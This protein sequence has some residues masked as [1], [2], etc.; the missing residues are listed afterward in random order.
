M[1][2]TA[3]TTG[4][5]VAD[6]VV[7]GGGRVR[8]VPAGDQ[9]II[10][11]PY[12][13]RDGTF[14]GL[15]LAQTADE[16]VARFGSKVYELMLYD[17][18]VACAF[19]LW[20]AGIVG[21]GL[22]VAP[23]VKTDPGEIASKRK[24]RAEIKL[25]EEISQALTWSLAALEEPVDQS[26]E[27]ML[28]AFCFGNAL[29]ELSFDW[30]ADGPYKDMQFHSALVPKPRW[31]YGY[32]VDSFNKVTAIRGWTGEGWQDLNRDHFAVLSW[33]PRYRDPRGRSGLRPAY[34]PWNFKHQEFPELAEYLHHFAQ[35]GIAVTAG[36]YQATEF[37]T[38]PNGL[39]EPR[40]VLDVIKD[41][42]E[43]YKGRSSLALPYGSSVTLIES[44]GDGK[45]YHDAFDRFDMEIFRA[46]IFSAR[47]LQEAKF[48]SKGDTESGRDLVEMSF[49][50]GR[51]PLARMFE[52]DVFKPFVRLNWGTAVAN[53][54]CPVANFGGQSS[55]TAQLLTA[56]AA[57]YNAGFIDEAQLPRLWDKLGLPPVDDEAL[58][59]RLERK[60]QILDKSQGQVPAKGKPPGPGN[61][62]GAGGRR[63]DPSNTGPG[64]GDS[65][66]KPTGT[67]PK[68]LYTLTNPLTRGAA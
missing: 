48:G 27:E 4:P 38:G 34:D 65:S 46:I 41:A 64:R 55:V 67:K 59:A 40:S 8:R 24:Q 68:R 22:Q 31:S 10:N 53:R 63:T 15:L 44:Q 13:G 33:K 45:A 29:A 21:D 5:T 1:I 43:A 52:R 14:A 60:E 9:A 32:R 12:L 28:D 30:V 61:G 51:K 47:P 56:M 58:K 17:P 42:L 20:K 66:K 16:V 50:D 39:Q 57:A 62:G 49:T 2:F 18:A 11:G 36:Q 6:R 35:P 23:R 54:L 37:V 3:D 19:A 25:A 26:A 7:A